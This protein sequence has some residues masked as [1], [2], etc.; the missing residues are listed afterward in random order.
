MTFVALGGLCA[1][2]LQSQNR[3]SVAGRARWLSRTCHHA[4]R[5]LRVRP[6]VSGV[7]PHGVMLTPNHVGYLDILVLASISPTTFVAKA[8]VA[9]WPIFGWFAA[10]AG[11]LFIRREKKS[12]LVRVG[13]QVAPVLAA[14]VNLVV[15]LE[16]TSTDG[17]GVQR[18]RPGLLEP[19]V[20][21]GAQVAPVAISYRVPPPR[22]PSV[23]VAWWGD[24]PLGSHLVNLVGIAWVEARVEFGKP[25]PSSI[26]RKTLAAELQAEVAAQLRGLSDS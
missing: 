22:D 17:K 18:F 5:V 19:I 13:Q 24:M 10:V 26:D 1:Y 23:E 9:R 21:L 7:V 4:L 11:T 2:L 20:Q 25:R 6:V 15:F 12:D 3:S 16:G 8:E 14:G